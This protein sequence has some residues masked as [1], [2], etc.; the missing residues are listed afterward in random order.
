MATTAELLAKVR[1][2][3]TAQLLKT[4][5]AEPDI[6]SGIARPED[7]EGFSI[8]DI[9]PRVS[10]AETKAGKVGAG[11]LDIL[12]V[13]ERALAA[14]ATEQKF[15]DPQATLFRKPIEAAKEKIRQIP[16]AE[17]TPQPVPIAGPLVPGTQLTGTG[18]RVMPGDIKKPLESIVELVGSAAG[19]PTILG[20]L[21]KK[22]LEAFGKKALR[23]GLKP[24]DVTARLAGRTTE[25]GA[26]KI[27]D[28]IVKHKV[29]SATGFGGTLKNINKKINELSG[30]VDKTIKQTVKN[31]PAAV[32]DLDEVY[33]KFI[34]DLQ[35]GRVPE[36]PFDE[37][38]RAVKMV[39]DFDDAL[40]KFEG[41]SGTVPL[42]VANVAK[43]K[44]GQKVFRKGGTGIAEDPLKNQVKE[45]LN[46]RIRDEMGRI[47]P[48]ITRDNKSISEL[49]T[50]R[51]AV[52]DAIK[53]LG[54]RNALFNASNLAILLSGSA[55][56]AVFGLPAALT[57]A[58]LIGAKTIGSAGRGAAGLIKAGRAAPVAAPAATVAPTIMDL[59]PSEAQ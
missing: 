40:A 6:T 37:K 36:I 56:T 23:S 45:L 16:E 48:A 13:P 22:P 33:I 12:T 26:K 46:L 24:K 9:F 8:G 30:D 3:S 32:V 51:K 58:G 20:A 25:E 50:A 53:R 29:E 17:Q 7:T 52:E 14:T 28:D 39:S 41:I 35:N 18:Q 2:Q 10:E 34:D 31:N 47:N 27:V 21:A 59:F 38:E 49:I 43:K 11:I 19:D 42:D 44:F 54:N 15:G 4:V 57:T 5:Q 55:P 1:E